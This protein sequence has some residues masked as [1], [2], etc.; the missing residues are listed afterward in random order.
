MNLT[1]NILVLIQICLSQSECV[2]N[3]I[4]DSVIYDD[5][6]LEDPYT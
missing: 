5:V 1:F 4:S 6:T 2:Y 3:F